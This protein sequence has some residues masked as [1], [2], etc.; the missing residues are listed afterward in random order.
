M[1][2]IDKI[3]Q[4]AIGDFIL[5]VIAC[6][7]MLV[8]F[9][10]FLAYGSFMAAK[11]WELRKFWKSVAVSLDK[12][13]NVSGKYALNQAMSHEPV[14]G[15]PLQTVSTAMFFGRLHKFGK[16]WE[17]RINKVDQ[18][19]FKKSFYNHKAEIQK[20]WELIKEYEKLIS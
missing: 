1:R 19:H 20:E 10:V 2:L 6:V 4:N 8:F 17:E 18:E 16:K 11:K 14:F 9:L 12:T 7:C 15:N 3:K 13:L 5:L